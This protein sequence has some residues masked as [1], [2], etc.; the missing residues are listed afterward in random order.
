MEEGHERG[1]IGRAIEDRPMAHE[2][3]EHDE[4]RVDRHDIRTAAVRDEPRC[5]VEADKAMLDDLAI[6]SRGHELA[7]HLKVV[8]EDRLALQAVRPH[9]PNFDGAGPARRP[10]KRGKHARFLPRFLDHGF[11]DR[12]AC[13]D[14]AADQVVEHAGIGCFRRAAPREPHRNIAGLADQSVHVCGKRANAEIPRGRTFEHEP[15]RCPDVR[16]D[17][18]ALVAPRGQR[19]FGRERAGDAI[20]SIRSR[21]RVVQRRHEADRVVIRPEDVVERGEA[22]GAKPI[23]PSDGVTVDAQRAQSLARW[24]QRR[25]EPRSNRRYNGGLDHPSL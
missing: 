10:G 6:L 19:A 5:G 2:A 21:L 1:G 18:I 20:E 25:R 4:A 13:C 7:G 23:N 14:S 8:D 22:S 12:L 15:R 11:G 17:G 24:R 3:I 16:G 9:A